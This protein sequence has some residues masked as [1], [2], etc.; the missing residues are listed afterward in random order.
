MKHQNRMESIHLQTD[1]QG[2]RMTIW[3]QP[4]AKKNGVTG[5]HQG[6]VRVSVTQVPEKGKATREILKVLAQALELKKSQVELITGETS[7][8]KVVL[9]TQID[10]QELLRRIQQ[11]LTP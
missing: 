6:M 1:P 5:I 11:Q 2:I 7:R 10:E 8:E 4:G 9:I 3:A